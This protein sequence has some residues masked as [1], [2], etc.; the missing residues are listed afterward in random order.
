VPSSA[1]SHVAT[2]PCDEQVPRRDWLKL[3][4]PSP[5]F[6]VAPLG[7]LDETSGLQTVLPAVLT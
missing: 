5:H 1:Q 4:V 3:Y 2:P 6:A 7:A